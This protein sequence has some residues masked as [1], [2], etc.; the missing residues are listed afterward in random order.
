M[1]RVTVRWIADQAGCSGHTVRKFADL[2][3][4]ESN[5]DYNGWRIFPEPDQAVEKIRKLMIFSAS[6]FI[7]FS[8]SVGAIPN[9]TT[10][11]FEILPT[12]SSFTD[13]LIDI[14]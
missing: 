12:I 2:G 10:S 8:P 11:P 4:I 13:T 3:M 6:H 1:K 14:D 9:R 7:S 5:R